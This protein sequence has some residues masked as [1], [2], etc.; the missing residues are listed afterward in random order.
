MS[1][2]PSASAAELDAFSRFWAWLA[3]QRTEARRWGRSVRVYCY[4]KGAEG[5][6][7]RRIA[8]RL[9]LEDEVEAFLSSEDWVDLMAVVR[10]Q[11]VTGTAM[12]LKTVAKLAGFQWRGEDGGGGLAMVRYAEAVD[13]A[14]DTDRVGVG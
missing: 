5:T 7:M 6:H 4:N 11:L 8:A 14:D 12:G 3:E 10:E 2:D 13:H 1:W 9:G